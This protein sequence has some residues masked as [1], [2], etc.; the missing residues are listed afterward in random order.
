MA[1][2]QADPVVP[3]GEDA[4]SALRGILWEEPARDDEFSCRLLER[5]SASR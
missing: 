5:L 2:F 1:W 4:D 3:S